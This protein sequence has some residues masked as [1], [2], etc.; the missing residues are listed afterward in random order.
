M[1]EREHV[2]RRLEI[3]IQLTRPAKDEYDRFGNLSRQEKILDRI[4]YHTNFLIVDNFDK[5]RSKYH[6]IKLEVLKEMLE[7]GHG[8]CRATELKPRKVSGVFT[9]S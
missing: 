4:E 2:L 6:T 7:E 9:R 8:K 3:E 1:S 5:N